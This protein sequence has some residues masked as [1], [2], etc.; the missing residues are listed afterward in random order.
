MRNAVAAQHG[1]LKEKKRYYSL[2]GILGVLGLRVWIHS[3]LPLV[4]I[5]LHFF[6]L[7]DDVQDYAVPLCLMLLLDKY[8]LL[9][10]SCE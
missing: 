4:H 1:T 2:A 5:F 3:P 8:L 10:T 7:W 6:S 9:S